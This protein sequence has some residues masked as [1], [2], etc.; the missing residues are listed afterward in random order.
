MESV[1]YLN[2]I[3]LSFQLK[4]VVCCPGVGLLYLAPQIEYSAFLPVLYI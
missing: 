2:F 1:V 4:V 3:Q